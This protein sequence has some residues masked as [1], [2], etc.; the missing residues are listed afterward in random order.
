M[1]SAIKLFGKTIR[2]GPNPYG[3]AVIASRIEASADYHDGC[4]STSSDGNLFCSKQGK[5]CGI[6][7]CSTGEPT[8]DNQGEESSSISILEVSKTQSTTTENLKTL[9]DEKDCSTQDHARKEDHSDQTS[10]NQSE[11][12]NPPK[13]PDEIL[14]CPR[15]NS[16]DTKFCYFNNYNLNQ[17][18]HFCKNCQRYWTAGGTM[19]NV[20]VGSGRRKNKNSSLLGSQP[21]HIV[22]HEAPSGLTQQTMIPG[23]RVFGSE[24]GASTL[25]RGGNS[26]SSG[27]DGFVRP[28]MRILAPC[29]LSGNQGKETSTGL[30]PPQMACFPGSPWPYAWNS[31]PWQSGCPLP[32]YT[33][34]PQWI[35][36]PPAQHWN[37]HLLQNPSACPD[38][39]SSS[40]GKHARDGTMLA[41]SNFNNKQLAK[42]KRSDNPTPQVLMPKTLRIIDDPI[43]VAR[44]SVCGSLAMK[45]DKGR[46]S[47]IGG[48]IFGGFH[49]Y[50]DVDLQRVN[51]T[52]EGS[53]IVN[54]T[55]PAAFSRSLSFREIGQ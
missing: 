14:P 53:H 35:C 16:M 44:S 40:L 4:D 45:I 49:P 39:N 38:S 26:S 23:M 15:C 3:D 52:A 20:P 51:A 13:K 43:E 21:N 55:N 9:S 2:L 24:S 41:P 34:P 12:Q 32:F 11:A 10:S 37:L 8:D 31:I 17:P 47:N 5:N 6:E 42:E 36:N 33:A 28:K 46:S 25:N 50:K 18:R 19:R 7:I 1:N 30:I 48:R 29:G 27:L 22:I 54:Q